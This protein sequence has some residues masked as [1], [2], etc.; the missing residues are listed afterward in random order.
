MWPQFNITQEI[1][2]NALKRRGGEG[3]KKKKKMCEIWKGNK[4]IFL[5]ME[6]AETSTDKL[7][8]LQKRIQQ[9]C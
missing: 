7:L 2:A 5:G 8:D 3:R 4:K 1:L 6:N 9:S